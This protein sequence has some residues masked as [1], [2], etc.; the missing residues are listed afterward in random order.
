M[1]H[2]LSLTKCR[3]EDVY[4]FYSIQNLQEKEGLETNGGIGKGLK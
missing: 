2:Y 3:R 1:Y 4:Y